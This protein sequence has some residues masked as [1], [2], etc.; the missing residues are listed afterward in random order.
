MKNLKEM[1][2]DIVFREKIL[3]HDF[4]KLNLAIIKLKEKIMFGRIR[5]KFFNNELVVRNDDKSGIIKFTLKDLPTLFAYYFD[6]IRIPIQNIGIQIE[7]FS[8]DFA[9]YLYMRTNHKFE[10]YQKRISIC[11]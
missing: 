1:K 8:R 2:H 9:Y 5:I 10:I 3:R 7:K 6:F 4:D 11:A